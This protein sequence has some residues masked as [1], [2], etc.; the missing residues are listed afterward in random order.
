[1]SASEAVK[2]TGVC[3]S[4]GGRI[5]S[6]NPIACIIKNSSLLK[7][8][9]LRGVKSRYEASALGLFW[10]FATPLVLLAVG[11]AGVIALRLRGNDTAPPPVTRV[12]DDGGVASRPGTAGSPVVDPAATEDNSTTD[13]SLDSGR[14]HQIH[15]AF[16]SQFAKSFANRTSPA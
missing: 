6:L 13:Q 2:R 4:G 10:A 12:G 1:M 3:G 8:L 9:T 11:G 14:P 5:N 16:G 7:Q 15:P